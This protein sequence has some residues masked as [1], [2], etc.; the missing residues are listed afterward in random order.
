MSAPCS[1]VTASPSVSPC[2]RHPVSDKC[3]V[4]GVVWYGMDDAR[5]VEIYRDGIFKRGFGETEGIGRGLGK[6]RKGENGLG[7]CNCLKRGCRLFT[8][9]GY[10]F[11]FLALK[12]IF[13]SNVHQLLKHDCSGTYDDGNFKKEFHQR[14]EME[15]CMRLI[16]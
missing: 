9:G 4:C 15:E 13:F 2:R 11:F 7:K 6:K 14:L 16:P 10:V 12:K 8:C 3:H 5:T 1:R